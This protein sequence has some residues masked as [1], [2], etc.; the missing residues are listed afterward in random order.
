MEIK[1]CLYSCARRRRKETD[2]NHQVDERKICYPDWARFAF[3][4]VLSLALS[5]ALSAALSSALSSALSAALSAGVAW[6]CQ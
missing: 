1:L 3:R 5:A 4:K 2:E 6:V